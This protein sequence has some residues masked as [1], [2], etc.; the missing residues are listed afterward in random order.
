[1]V[2]AQFE[3]WE[4]LLFRDYLLDHPDMAKEYSDLKVRLAES[5]PSDRIACTN[6]K[7][8]FIKAVT[9]KA[10]YKA[11]NLKTIGNDIVTFMKQGLTLDSRLVHFLSSTFS[12]T[13]L[14][15]L[16][17]LKNKGAED[18][19]ELFLD[20][21]V[22]PDLGILE[23]LE[24]LIWGNVFTIHDERLLSDRVINIL[25]S[26]LFL[27]P[28]D[29]C[30]ISFSVE[31]EI[32]HHYIKKLHIT[33]A[34][35]SSLL[36]DMDQRLTLECKVKTCVKLRQTGFPINIR[37]ISF[38]SQFISKSH[39]FD[40]QYSEH[41]DL[42]LSILACSSDENDLKEDLISRLRAFQKTQDQIRT[43]EDMMKKNTM[44]SLMLQ[45]FRIPPSS[46]D[47]INKNITMLRRILSF[48]Y[49]WVDMGDN[50]VSEI[51]LGH[52]EGKDSMENVIRLL[53]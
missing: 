16:E 44:E 2:E 35:P 15:E 1:M 50:S 10:K 31:P 5:H 27:F 34:I 22:S 47:V 8:N 43:A 48:L 45:G 46:P 12:I 32:I 51:D 49:G 13:T 18:E 23:K 6:A 19:R 26:L 25:P 33:Y 42:A 41:L 14:K 39:C 3:H 21:A 52:H 40:E 29:P 53:S 24:H 37:N 17:A 7:T 30:P 36:C 11:D 9:E 20:L 28:G 4:K 38:L